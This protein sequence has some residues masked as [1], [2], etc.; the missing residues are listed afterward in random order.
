MYHL[1]TYLTYCS[2]LFSKLDKMFVSAPWLV[3]T[4]Q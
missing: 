2:C 1:G 3:P 4:L